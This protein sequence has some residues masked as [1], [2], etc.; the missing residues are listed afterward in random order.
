MNKSERKSNTFK[1]TI[2]NLFFHIRLVNIF[3]SFGD[4]H[5]KMKT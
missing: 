2:H 1:V 4:S 5:V 3:S